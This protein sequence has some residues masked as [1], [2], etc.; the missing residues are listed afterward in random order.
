MIQKIAKIQNTKHKKTID[1]ILIVLGTFLV[2]ASVKLIYD[3]MK[4]VIGGFGGLSVVIKYLA[5]NMGMDIP[6]WL[7]NAVLNVPV[8]IIAFF[9]LGKA[10]VAKTLLGA[11]A[12]GLWLYVI[13][14]VD[15]C[16]GDYLLAIVFGGLLDGIGIG[17][18]LLTNS[19]SG[20]TDMV[21][22][23]LHKFFKHYSVPSILFVVDGL[24]VLL[25]AA[26]FGFKNA[27]YGTIVI[28]LLTKISDAIL[29]GVKFAKIVYI[30]SD[31]YEDIANAIMTDMDRGVTAIYARGMYTNSEKNMLFCV[32]DKK[33][34]VH[35]KEVVS[36][37]DAK[38]F[39]IVNDAREVFGEGFV[40]HNHSGAV[41]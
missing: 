32:M 33:E 10:F 12:F 13:P 18:V 39:V 21:S 31:K 26:V 2:A 19:T 5:E 30:I 34:I 28:Y 20:G 37:I 9:L 36:S 35:L 38:A 23:L 22:A 1:I 15:V 11:L 40:E 7:T 14:T 6:V 41:H 8:F 17:F 4:L 25:G 27:M 3:P 29:Q 16:G 24:I